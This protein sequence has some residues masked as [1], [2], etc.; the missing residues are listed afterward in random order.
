MSVDYVND[1]PLVLPLPSQRE[2]TIIMF[3][4][5]YIHRTIFILTTVPVD[6]FSRYL[7]LNP[8]EKPKKSDRPE[9]CYLRYGNSYN[10]V[11]A[12]EMEFQWMVATA[13]LLNEM[14]GKY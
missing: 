11:H 7:E 3:L 2:Q 4:A 14:V 5:N 9:W 10:P 13:S 8:A 12:Y 1:L 6:F